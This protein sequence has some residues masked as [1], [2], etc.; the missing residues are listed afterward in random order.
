MPRNDDRTVSDVLQDIFGNVQDIVRS[1]IR[2]ATAEIKSEAGNF[3]RA[4]KP[5]VTGAVLLLYACGLLLL[6]VVYALSLV[7]QPWIAALL[8]C[9]VVAII[10]AIFL[11]VGRGRLRIVH[12]TPERTIQNIKENV[13]WLKDQTR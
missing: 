7:L 2:L 11:S 9:V 3:A 12:S 13:R 1:E 6:S 8:V 10:A 5:L 4:G